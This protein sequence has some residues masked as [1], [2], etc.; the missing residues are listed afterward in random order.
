MQFSRWGDDRKGS[1]ATR[2]VVAVFMFV[3]VGI[4]RKWVRDG[5]VLCSYS[6]RWWE[7]VHR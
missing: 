4:G 7:G 3:L 1:L 6:W 2:W 5:T